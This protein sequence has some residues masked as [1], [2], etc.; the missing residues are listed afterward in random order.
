[1]SVQE[2]IKDRNKSVSVSVKRIPL[3]SLSEWKIDKS[4]SR[5][6]IINP[7]IFSIK[8]LDIKTNYGADTERGINLSY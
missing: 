8:G 3:K 1:M 7:N 4:S 2:W 5:K 6:F